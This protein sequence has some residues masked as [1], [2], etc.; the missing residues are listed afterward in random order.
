MPNILK[1]LNWA[2]Q[3]AND[4]SHGYDQGNRQGPDYDCSSL[5][6][7]ALRKGGFNINKDSYTGNLYSQLKKAGFKEVKD[8]SDRQAGDIFLT[9]GHH[10]VMCVDA[11][12]IVHA[13]GNEKGK[14]TGG[15]EGDQTGKEICIRSWYEPKYK[16]KYHLRY[17]SPI[18]SKPE[19]PIY[20]IPQ[21]LI[22]V[23]D[24][25]HGNGDERKNNLASLG[26]DPDTIQKLVN[27]MLGG[28]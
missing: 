10:V 25:K 11:D 21:I 22:D 18:I 26:Y 2:I 14:I 9:P 23:A 4:N 28:D 15:K 3:T 16:W 20:M 13:S 7:N 1:A 8:N 19:E 24:G 27:Q 12:R 17:D 5:I 6:A